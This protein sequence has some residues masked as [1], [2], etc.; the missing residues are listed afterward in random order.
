MIV[1][2]FRNNYVYSKY[3]KCMNNPQI[4]PKALFFINFK[5]Q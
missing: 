1:A 3:E 5:E 2:F 4:I